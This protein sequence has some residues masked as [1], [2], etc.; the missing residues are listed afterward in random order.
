MRLKFSPLLH[1][2]VLIMLAPSATHF[3]DA[4]CDFNPS[5]PSRAI[6]ALVF[7]MVL[8]ISE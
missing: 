6:H 1:I 8:R 2:S 4:K 5:A 3:V 7:Y